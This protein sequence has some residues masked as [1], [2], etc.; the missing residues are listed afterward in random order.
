MPLIQEKLMEVFMPNEKNEIAG[1][2]TGTV[3]SVEEKDIRS[4]TWVTIEEICNGEWSIGGKAVTTDA[5]APPLPQT[6]N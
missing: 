6:I 1:Q 4:V 3:V 5:G 2:L